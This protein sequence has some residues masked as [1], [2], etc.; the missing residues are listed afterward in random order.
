MNAGVEP[1]PSKGLNTCILF[2]EFTNE[3]SYVVKGPADSVMEVTVVW[4]WGS[5]WKNPENKKAT[6]FIIDMPH[7]EILLNLHKFVA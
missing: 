6:S 7:S 2:Q 5:H 1:L 4:T 3:F